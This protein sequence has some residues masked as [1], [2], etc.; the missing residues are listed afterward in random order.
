MFL[1]LQ[2][3]V[4][5]A[6]NFSPVLTLSKVMPARMW[7]Q[8][9]QRGLP[10]GLFPSWSCWGGFIFALTKRSFRFLGR[11]LATNGGFGTAFFI[12]FKICRAGRW[13]QRIF[14]KDESCGWKVTTN[15]TLSVFLISLLVSASVLVT[16]VAL[17]ICC[18]TSSPLYPRWTRY[19]LSSSALL[20]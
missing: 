10:Q 14:P 2:L 20:M 13:S 1:V 8:L 17:S 7:T 11:L 15:G 3:A 18:W 12:F 9:L 4:T 16:L 5:R 6:W 19:S